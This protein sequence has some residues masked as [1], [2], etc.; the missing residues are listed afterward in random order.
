MKMKSWRFTDFLLIQVFNYLAEIIF[1]EV[2][3]QENFTL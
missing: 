1:F 2:Y 3:K